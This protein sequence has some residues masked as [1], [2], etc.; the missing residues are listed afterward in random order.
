MCLLSKATHKKQWEI[1]PDYLGTLSYENDILV[2]MSIYLRDTVEYYV[3]S[4]CNTMN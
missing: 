1:D 2:K 4:T 3:C